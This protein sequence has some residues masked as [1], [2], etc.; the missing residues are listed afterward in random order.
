MAREIRIT[1]DDDEVF[2]RMK[3]TKQELDLSWRE[4]LHRGLQVD[5]QPQN[6]QRT[7]Q[8]PDVDDHDTI[9]DDIG[10][11]IERQVKERIESSLENALGIETYRRDRDNR[12]P[13][14]YEDDVQSLENAEDAVITFP[15]LDEAP[16]YKIPL[17]V[18]LEMRAGGVDVTVVT[19]RQGK[20]V[21]GMN[22]FDRSTR[23]RIAEG[24]ATGSS[25]H[26][27]LGG[28]EE[29]YRVTPVLSWGRDDDGNPTVDTVE[30]EDVVFEE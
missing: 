13:T 20:S 5:S 14:R 3:R 10:D 9:E 15:F 6:R 22:A 24:L 16:A 18:E 26:L 17:R 1:I 12:A 19:V 30:I 2:A 21:D 23:H 8:E 11:R 25:V 29:T 28:G 7:R 4:V 27:E